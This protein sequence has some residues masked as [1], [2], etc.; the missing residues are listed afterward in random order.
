[1]AYNKRVRMRSAPFCIYGDKMSSP[2]IGVT[3]Y[4]G[5][6]EDGYPITALQRAYIDAVKNAGGV[7]ILLPCGLNKNAYQDLFQRLAGI[8]FTGG[9][10]IDTETYNGVQHPRVSN[11]DS[12][13]DFLEFSLLKLLVDEG[14]PFLGI[15][16]GFQIL[17]VGLGG[18]LYT[19][20]EDQM[21]G[22][23]KH[24]YYPNFPRTYL[25]HRVQVEGRSRLA[26]ILGQTEIFVNSLHHQGAKDIPVC[27]KPVG[28]APDGLVEAVELTNHPFCLAV[29]WHPEWLVDQLATQELFR[30]FVEA[31]FHYQ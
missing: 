3:A 7:P 23:I 11:V 25:A 20:I 2:L 24:D 16:R 9:G 28:Y 21:T 17:V 31:A 4:Q 30:V 18:S 12:E 14:K 10:D 6:N 29:Q 13:R 8:L 5:I 27:L 22:S 15:C 1:M 26:E 19:H